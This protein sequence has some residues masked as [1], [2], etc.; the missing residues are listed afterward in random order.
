MMT[1]IMIMY[2]S[3]LQA[4]SFSVGYI[5]SVQQ[6][7]SRVTIESQNRPI[8]PLGMTN[9]CA[10]HSNEFIIFGFCLGTMS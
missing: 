8:Y 10:N 9:V 4:P 1:G 5:W 3:L 6:D 7:F 2:K